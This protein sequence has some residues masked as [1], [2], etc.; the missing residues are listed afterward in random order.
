[1]D[2]GLGLGQPSKDPQGQPAGGWLPDQCLTLPEAIAAFSQGAAWAAFAD[3]FLGRLQIGYQADL[4]A[5]ASDLR[6]LTPAELREAKVGA[7]VI[8]GRVRYRAV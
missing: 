4:T 2:R 8:A 6:T 5:F 7:T 3:G 1:M